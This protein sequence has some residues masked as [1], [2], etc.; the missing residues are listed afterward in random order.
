MTRVADDNAMLSPAE[1]AELLGVPV[2]TVYDWNREG[3]AP[4]RYRFGRHV[5]YAGADV[6]EW[7]RGHRHEPARSPTSA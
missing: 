5:R 7:I 4:P 3:T 1:L 6:N 2:T